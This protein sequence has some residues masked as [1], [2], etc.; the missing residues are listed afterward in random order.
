MRVDTL[1]QDVKEKK[2]KRVYLITGND[3]WLRHGFLKR[4]LDAVSGD[5]SMNRMDVSGSTFSLPE[6]RAFTDT[7]PFFADRRVLTVTDSGLFRSGKKNDAPE[8][9]DDKSEE[10]TPEDLTPE[11]GT[12]ERSD[13]VQN[14]L[15][16]LPETAVVIFSETAC[17]GRNALY[18]LVGKIG[19]VT[20]AERPKN[21]G[22]LRRFAMNLIGKSGLRIT[23][24]AFDMLMERLPLDYGMAE[25]EIEKLISYC[26]E[27]GSILPDDVE[28]MTAP[29]LEDRVFDLVEK[30]SSGDRK[31]AMDLYYDLVRLRTSPLLILTL[32]GKDLVRLMNVQEMSRKGLSDRE[33]ME[34]LSFRYDW[35]TDKY[36]R[37][38][39]RFRKGALREA[40][41]LEA[42]L[43]LSVK[44]GNLGDSAAAEMLILRLTGRDLPPKRRGSS[45]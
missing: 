18:K 27:K 21:P 20:V 23:S 19:S 9:G 29:R 44:N 3:P 16:T 6:L 24:G 38:A 28:Q 42:D 4:L 34:A 33:I 39:G 45:A 12:K 25:T 37:T 10:E 31:G 5:D 40:A 8:D 2:F 11:K 7:M 36:R 22:E 26:L 41:A 15:R 17:D 1:I 35:I 14:W 13:S 30:V 43:E 32:I